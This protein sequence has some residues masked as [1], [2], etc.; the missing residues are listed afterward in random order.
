M[1]KS[2]EDIAAAFNALAHPR[3][4]EIYRLIAAPVNG[5]PDFKT[6][7]LQTGF[8]RSVVFFHLQK[9]LDGHLICATREGRHMR[10]RPN[11]LAFLGFTAPVLREIQAQVYPL[12]A[13]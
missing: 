8:K 5:A 11:G 1:S 4:I 2:K 10:Y 7:C 12:R 6:L 9:M 3:R 13:A